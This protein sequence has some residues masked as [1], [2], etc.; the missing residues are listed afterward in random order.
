MILMVGFA[1]CMTSGVP[2]KA[3]VTKAAKTIPR[4][5]SADTTQREFQDLARWK[6]IDAIKENYNVDVSDVKARVHWTNEICP[7]GKPGLPHKL[8]KTKSRPNPKARCD[9]GLHFN[10][11]DIYVA[12]HHKKLGDGALIHE[13]GHCYY[14]TVFPNSEV[15]GNTNHKNKKWWGLVEKID[16]ELLK[17]GW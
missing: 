1:A 13:L 7:D 14:E 10:C 8:L 2:N 6:Y 17:L 12:G 16:K 11:M 4:Y 15:P 3:T 9:N 5:P